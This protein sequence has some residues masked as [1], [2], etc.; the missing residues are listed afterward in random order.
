MLINIWLTSSVQCMCLRLVCEVSVVLSSPSLL[1]SPTQPPHCLGCKEGKELL[2]PKSYDVAGAPFC[3]KELSSQTAAG[4]RLMGLNSGAE[5]EERLYIP[6]LW[7]LSTPPPPS[8]PVEAV[9][10]L[11]YFLLLLLLLVDFGWLVLL[12]C[13]KKQLY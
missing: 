4:S 3:E 8:P 13:S 12:F 7:L 2:S 1:P 11:Q 10:L 5:A 6:T 9:E